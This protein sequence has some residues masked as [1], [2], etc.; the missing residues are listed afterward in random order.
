MELID[1]H[2][3]L[4]SSNYDKDRQGVI[5]EAKKQGIKYIINVGTNI[6]SSK[7]SIALSQKNSGIYATV[8][9]HPH[10]ADEVD[11][12]TLSFLEK[13]TAE[14]KVVAVGEIGLD[15]HYDNSPRDIQ[16]K[17]FHLQLE[18]A[19][20]VN[21][22]VVIHSRD[23]A[24]ETLKILKEENIQDIGGIFH[25]FSEDLNTARMILDMGMYIAVGGVITFKN[26][27]GLRQVVAELPLNRLVIETDSPYLT[28]HPHRG[29]RNEPSY[30][31]YVAREIARIK[32]ISQVQVAKITT[33][34]AKKI[35]NIL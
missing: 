35:Y 5:K 9:I 26:A 12:N 3:H 28:P 24:Q 32:N 34:N 18:L 22:P 6:M 1:T 4:D 29:H 11:N 31:K 14:D 23:A 13:L 17:A 25:C 27:G 30:I 8:G 19:R 16:K 21:L 7:N 20:K 33:E 2:A 15:F 10:D